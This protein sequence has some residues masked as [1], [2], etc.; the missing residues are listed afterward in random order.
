MSP[1]YI[2]LPLKSIALEGNHNSFVLVLLLLEETSSIE[3]MKR[4]SKKLLHYFALLM[5]AQII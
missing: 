4:N 1:Q 2:K 3:N 5:K